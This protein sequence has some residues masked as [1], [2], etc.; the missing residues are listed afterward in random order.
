M[1]FHQKKKSDLGSSCIMSVLDILRL[2]FIS[3]VNY[4]NA[5]VNYENL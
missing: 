5:S 3:D 4:K 1:S 2:L